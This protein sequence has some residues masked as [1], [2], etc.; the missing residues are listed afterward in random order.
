MLSSRNQFENA[1]Y[2]GVS[3]PVTASTIK[4]VLKDPSTYTDLENFVFV[5]VG[6]ALVVIKLYPG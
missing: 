1:P 3:S 5:L 4:R 6:W 2:P